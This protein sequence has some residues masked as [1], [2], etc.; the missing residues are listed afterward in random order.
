MTTLITIIV[1]AVGATL[2][3][4]LTETKVSE[5]LSQSSEVVTPL[6]SWKRGKMFLKKLFRDDLF[7]RLS[8]FSN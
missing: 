2:R 1:I 4:S 7:N 3:Y 6:T 5:F 8:A